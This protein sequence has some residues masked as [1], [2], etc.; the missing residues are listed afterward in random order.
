MARL[1]VPGLERTSLEEMLLGDI[2]R[3]A[4]SPWP[5]VEVRVVRDVVVRTDPRRVERIVT[6]LI[7]NAHRHGAPPVV[8]DVNGTCLRVRD[9]GPGFP[10]H[11]LAHGPVRF[12]TGAA[13]GG[14]TGTGLGLGLTIVAGQ[15]KVLG[16]RVRHE[17]TASGGA[18][19]TVDFGA[20]RDG[21]TQPER[22]QDASTAD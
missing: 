9:H 13:D 2:A 15:A 8:L 3:R 6:N 19:V 11:L 5:N 22:T 17:N 10:E 14:G 18:S 7:T 16:V 12:R 21:V 20:V 4:A 1:D